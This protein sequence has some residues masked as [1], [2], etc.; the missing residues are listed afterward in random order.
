MTR[1]FAPMTRLAEIAV[2]D[3]A[4]VV[5]LMNSRRFICLSGRL[6][7]DVHCHTLCHVKQANYSDRRSLWSAVARHRFCSPLRYPGNDLKEAYSGLL[8]RESG[9]SGDDYP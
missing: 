2:V 9:E 7:I 1:S 3:I 4:A 5:C 6:V 8:S